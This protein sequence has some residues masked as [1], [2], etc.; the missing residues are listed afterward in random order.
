[1]PQKCKKRANLFRVAEKERIVAAL[2]DK[3]EREGGAET[4][5]YTE[6]EMDETEGT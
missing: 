6:Y 4:L 2:T 5:A 1:M 3:R